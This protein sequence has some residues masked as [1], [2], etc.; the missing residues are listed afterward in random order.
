MKFDFL[1]IEGNIGSGKTSLAKKIASDF[2][3][4]LILGKNGILGEWGHN[5]LP[6]RELHDGDE[7]RCGCGRYGCIETYLNGLALTHDYKSITGQELDAEAIARVAGAGNANA[8][9]AI[10]RYSNRLAKAL[11]SVVNLLDPDVIVLGGG[12]SQIGFIYDRVPKV[13]NSN[14]V[15]KSITTDIRKAIHGPDSGMRGAAYL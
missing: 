4:K 13:W 5:P 6:W 15:T 7:K 12:L 9:E 11:A 14:T 2:N 1:T 10:E 3:G 8:I